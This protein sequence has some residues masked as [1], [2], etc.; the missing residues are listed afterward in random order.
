[1]PA[2]G[3][4][5]CLFIVRYEPKYFQKGKLTVFFDKQ[6]INFDGKDLYFKG[7]VTWDIL[8]RLIKAHGS[9]VPDDEISESKIGHNASSKIWDLKNKLN[10]KGFYLVA[11]SIKRNGLGFCI[12]MKAF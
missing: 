11:N 1:M 5:K 12:N 2:I 9:M 10:K 8:E 6:L 4:I 3:G 7:T